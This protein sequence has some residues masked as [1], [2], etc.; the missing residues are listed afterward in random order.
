M[1]CRHQLLSR[2]LHCS[3]WVQHLLSWK[4]CLSRVHYHSRSYV[5]SLC[6]RN[7]VL[8]HDQFP[9]L[10]H[11]RH[12]LRW[13]IRVKRLH[14]NS[15]YLVHP[16]PSRQLLSQPCHFHRH[17]VWLWAVLSCR[18]HQLLS[19]RHRL[20]LLNLKRP[21]AMRPGLVLPG[22]Y[23]LSAAVSCYFLLSQHDNCHPVRQHVLLSCELHEN[24]Q[25]PPGLLLQHY[26]HQD[27]LHALDLLPHW[28]NDQRH[29]PGRKLLSRH[30]HPDPLCLDQL[31]S[32]WLHQPDPVPLGLILPG[33][34]HQDRM[35]F[36][37][38]LCTRAHSATDLSS[39][40]LLCR[41]QHK[42]SM[43]CQQLL[44]SRSHRSQFMHCMLIWLLHQH[45]LH[46]FHQ[47]CLHP[48]RC[49]HQLCV[50]IQRLRLH[51][52]RDLRPGPVHH[53]P[54]HRHGQCHLRHLSARQ[55]LLQPSIHYAT[56][57]QSR[58]ILSCWIN[59]TRR[60]PS[61]VLLPNRFSA[62]GVSRGELLSREFLF[63]AHMH[64]MCRRQVSQRRVHLDSRHG[65]PFVY[66]RDQLLAHHQR[67]VVLRV[68][69]VSRAICLDS[70]H[71]VVGC[72]LFHLSCWK[73][74]S[75]FIS[76][77]AM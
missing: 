63:C 5:L 64:C 34:S 58:P 35:Q 72:S 70:M 48:V 18:L 20:L 30:A 39:W 3:H 52:M 49:R 19:V 14:G 50:G 44:S 29:M 67:S 45:A 40:V 77:R 13:S 47:C 26:W 4:L 69:H 51:D 41:S 24:G 12:L 38:L 36:W 11:V 76:H 33:H 54:V 59:H 23:G 75:E 21:A 71:C 10:H 57:M 46:L 73:L 16:M 42:D 65:V 31:L 62:G 32:S 2:W 28:L 22:W 17:L 7:L 74:L 27:P 56:G 37:K 60:M 53:V 68:Q 55:L 43:S 66:C 61:R 1:C 15:Q 8:D 9:Q 25:V 6:R